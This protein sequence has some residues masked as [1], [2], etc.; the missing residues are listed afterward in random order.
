MNKK[1]LGVFVAIL[2]VAI[3]ALPISVVLAENNENDKFILV[4]G[5]ASYALAGSGTTIVS[6]VVGRNFIW[7]KTGVDATWSG[8]IEADDA[9]CDFRTIFFGFEPPFSSEGLVTHLTWTLINPIIAGELYEGELVISGGSRNWRIV[10]GTGEL[11]N[12][13]GQG[14]QG[15]AGPGGIAYEGYV[16]FDP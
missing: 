16:H 14:T 3:L 5:G 2:E 6:S 10:G 15:G 9:T 11:A 7:A 12:I 8:T 13:H 1:V 4:E